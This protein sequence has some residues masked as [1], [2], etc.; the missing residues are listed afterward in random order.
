MNQIHEETGIACSTAKSICSNIQQGRS[1]ETQLYGGRAK[2]STGNVRKLKRILMAR[3]KT[4]SYSS[5]RN[6]Q[7]KY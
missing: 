2:L 6:L 5:N 3:Q 4:H 7:S 1:V